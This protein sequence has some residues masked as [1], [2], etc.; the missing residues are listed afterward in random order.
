MKLIRRT[1]ALLIMAFAL[2]M[3]V[4]ALA[5]AADDAVAFE[6]ESAALAASGKQ[7]E[8]AGA[9]ETT[10]T[11]QASESSDAPQA[12]GTSEATH[13]PETPGTP[14]TPEVPGNP[15][16][17][18]TPDTP[19]NPQAP[20]TPEAS[21][22][23]QASQ[24][25]ENQKSQADPASGEAAPGQTG[26]GDKNAPASSNGGSSA[27]KAQT[28]TSS[29]D[30]PAQ[31]ASTPKSSTTAPAKTTAPATAT[32]A[33]AT[34]ATTAKTT[35]ATTATSSSSKLAAA[36]TAKAT[37]SAKTAAA[38]AASTLQ[39]ASTTSSSP[40]KLNHI[41]LL[42]PLSATGKALAADYGSNGAAVL[43]KAFTGNG[44]QQWKLVKVGTGLYALVNVESGCRLD[45]SGAQKKAGASTLVWDANGGANQQWRFVQGTNGS[46]SILTALGGN[47]C[48]DASGKLAKSTSAASQSWQLFDVTEMR[49][50]L[51][52][53][54][55]ASKGK[56]KAGTY[57]FTP[58]TSRTR[59]LDVKG[60]SAADGANVDISTPTMTAGQKWT[61]SFDG[62]GYATIK[63][64]SGKLLD[65]AGASAASGTNVLMWKANGGMNQKWIITPNADGTWRIASAMWENVSLDVASTAKGA[66][67]RIAKTS[68]GANQRWKPYSTAS[69]APT[70]SAVA[71]G[72]YTLRSALSKSTVQS[73]A[74]FLDVT[75][76]KVAN[77]TPLELYAGNGGFAQ[78]FRIYKSGKYYR[79]ESAVCSGY[80][81]DVKNGCPV[82]GAAGQIKKVNADETLFALKKNA[83]GSYQFVNV[84]TGLA[85]DAL[86][87]KAANGSKVTGENYVAGKAS[88]SFFLVARHGLLNA[89]F[90]RIS[91]ALSGGRA[92]SVRNANLK[93]G[94]ATELQDSYSA[95]H[96]KWRVGAVS[97]KSNT[98]T[99]ES[100]WSGMRLSS[101]K[102]S[103]ATQA[104]ASTSTAQQWVPTKVV[105]GFEWRNVATGQVL[106]VSGASSKAGTDVLCWDSNGAKNQRWTMAKV[107][108]VESGIYEISPAASQ[109]LALA[110]QGSST[111]GGAN[112][113]LQKDNASV[114]Q[115]WYYD[116][117]SGT[118]TNMASGLLIDV[119]GGG[120][121]SG[122][123]VI[124][125]YANGGK[126][127]SWKLVYVGGGTFEIASNLG[128]SLALSASSGASGANVSNKTYAKAAT[129]RWRMSK[130]KT[131]LSS[132]VK[133]SLK[134][135]SMA[136]VKMVGI[137]VSFWNG[138]INW[139]AVKAAGIEFAILRVGY[140][141]SVTDPQFANYVKGCR[142]NGIPF[143]VYYYSTAE[144]AA[145]AKNEANRT[146]SIMKSAGVTPSSIDYCIYLD[147]EEP[148]MASTDKRGVLA[149]I[150][151]AFLNT[152]ANAGYRG[153]VYSSTS[154]WNSYLTYPE[155][156][157][158]ERWVAHWGVSTCGYQGNYKIWQCTSDGSVPGI[159]GRVDMDFMY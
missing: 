143:G 111:E 115:K 48:L 120:A 136:N 125:W 55:A 140:G 108:A 28:T 88:Q 70:T 150:T 29:P 97:G 74:F 54:A 17:P 12:S 96:Q 134:G 86:S 106:D 109:A 113:Q 51:D 25:P 81:L 26:S 7:A 59:V 155:F 131:V 78:I 6:A 50:R 37:V 3:A 112:V 92:L 123:N 56:V 2:L 33:K 36:S 152:V 137:D 34:T 38:K 91:T 76:E 68:T 49:A 151:N 119:S 99:I 93:A 98:Y 46:F 146:L 61:I 18:G 89:G 130:Q 57:V 41:F 66:N 75:G 13:A 153:G 45:V 53:Q 40:L 79:I 154:W 5:F 124:Q 83:N 84:K 15:Q 142:A 35:A 9:P 14:G 39:A 147:L 138:D 144:S 117:K 4:P 126:N 16:A 19:G 64:G 122:S 58:N 24:N 116:A 82:P 127:Q 159:N 11:P 63:S 101:A 20:E 128:N 102:Y 95:L 135:I 22:N 94:A 149:S 80:N 107:D 148:K 114:S 156:S 87:G 71:A 32:T 73:K 100:I 90:Y 10:Q 110:V 52:Q 145:E 47:L 85:L 105:G 21:E 133:N 72:W 8:G 31:A 77:G 67:V 118:L 23:P 132:Q 141:K 44:L 60:A 42:R 157:K 121:T 139:A 30:A 158:W 104:K 62:K 103:K 129:Q 69:K 27:A 65:V 1:L 43:A